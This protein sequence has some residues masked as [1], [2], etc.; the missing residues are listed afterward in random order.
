MIGK[1]YCALTMLERAHVLITGG[2][3]AIGSALSRALLKRDIAT[4]TII[5]D[6]SS[7]SP[8]ATL[9]IV[10]DSRVIHLRR[11]IISDEC[12][13]HALLE[14]PQ[15]IVF[16]LA[17]NFA[18]Q[19][20]L[21]HPII[22]CEVN[23]LGT[24][25]VLEYARKADVKK[26]VFASSSCVYGNAKSYDV[27]TKDFHLDTPYA[28]NKLHGEYL[29]NFYREHHGMNTTILRYFNSFGP[30]EL[31]GRYRNVIPNFF[32]RAMNGQD[33]PITG[34]ETVSR[35]FNYVENTAQGTILA[36]E[37]PIS[38]G[39]IY[40]IGSG[41]EI[42]IVELAKKINAITGNKAGIT[43]HPARVWD[44]IK[45]RCADISLTV[46][47]L[48]YKPVIDFDAQLQVTYQWLKEHQKHFPKV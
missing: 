14:R 5:D 35:D 40:N 41:N 24:A 32:A 13:R 37:K 47:E 8:D 9:D 28:I 34:D 46:K 31:P 4:L 38:A 10:H 19:S 39:K 36:A 43:M 2:L 20:S 27:G 18:H 21:D 3:G 16:H 7:S 30:G 1:V 48:G 23:S 42:T 26:F 44:S 15:D 17:A 11:S 33:L 25:K 22:D 45:N 29:V 6:F 12:L